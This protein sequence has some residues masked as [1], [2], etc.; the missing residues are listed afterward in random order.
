MTV[1]WQKTRAMR[2]GRKD[3]VCSVEVNGERVEQVK[4]MQY[5]GVMISGD[6]YM[7][8]EV[9]QR[10]GKASKMIGAIGNTVLGRKELMK[11]TKLKVVNA[12]VIPTLT[13]GCEVWALQAKHKGRIQAVQMRVLRRIKGVSRLDRISNMDLRD[14]L[15]HEGVL[16]CVRRRQQNWKQRLEEMSSSRVTKKVLDGK[17]P[18]KC[19]RGRPR[20]RLINNFE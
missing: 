20:R 2:I 5:L 8:R 4:E 12:M 18:G 11:G 13:Y 7:D 17:I 14:R 10:I 15:K 3:E 6:G 19:P 1:N 16:D 9:E